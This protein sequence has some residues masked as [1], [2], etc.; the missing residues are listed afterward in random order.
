MTSSFSSFLRKEICGSCV[1][2]TRAVLA[3]VLDGVIAAMVILIAGGL[4]CLIALA[5]SEHNRGYLEMVH[6][7]MSGVTVLVY[8]C[9]GIWDGIKSVR[10]P[11]VPPC[12]P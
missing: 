7:I 4:A 9:W 5:L 12:P 2:A 10:E 8:G 6:R 11:T 1:K 3:L